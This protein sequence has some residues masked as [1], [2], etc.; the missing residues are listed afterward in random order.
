MTITSTAP[1]RT[2]TRSTPLGASP[3]GVRLSPAKPRRN[4]PLIAVGVLLMVGFGLAAAVLQLHAAD[5]TVVLAVAR[6][7]PIGQE[8]RPGDL[9]SVRISID[10]A[11]RPI[12]ASELSSVVG[13][14]AAVPLVPGALLT[15]GQIAD[16]AGLPKGKVVVGLALKAGQ[17]PANTLRVGDQVLVVAT[18]SNRAEQ[19]DG[20]VLVRQATVYGLG[21]SSHGV[22]GTT[23]ISIV[24]D[25]ADAASVATAGSAGQISVVLRAAS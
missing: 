17:L 16:S 5:R 13:R 1:P 22:D 24:V 18:G 6:P 7:V 3:N 9:S 2:S 21:S 19:A 23:T 4:G 20:A 25:E 11:L 14:A 15:R 8:I 12:P 10:P